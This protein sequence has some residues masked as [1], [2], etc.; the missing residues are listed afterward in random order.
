M[1]WTNEVHNLFWH[2]P[3][4]ETYDTYKIL[5]VERGPLFW[6]FIV[7]AFTAVFYSIYLLGRYFFTTRSFY[8][9]QI[10]SLLAAL[11]LPTLLGFVDAIYIDKPIDFAP[12]FLGTF[13]FGFFALSLSTRGRRLAPIVYNRI[14]EYM[15]DALLVL[16]HK[17]IIRELNTSAERIL[18]TDRATALGL[19]FTSVWPGSSEHLTHVLGNEETSLELQLEDEEQTHIFEVQTSLIYAPELAITKTKLAIHLTSGS[20]ASTPTTANI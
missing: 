11:F 10:S 12:I 16:D 7:Y 4:Q 3:R 2:S 20:G 14:L 5:V 15:P 9:W 17:H 13:T 18:R 1:A 19:P 8:N 6:V